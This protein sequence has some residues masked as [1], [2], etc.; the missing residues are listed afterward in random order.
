MPRMRSSSE[1]LRGKKRELLIVAKLGAAEG[2]LVPSML[3]A[4]G[5]AVRT[6]RF[7]GRERRIPS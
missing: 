1:L 2:A 5:N 6:F 7:D 3:G 4:D